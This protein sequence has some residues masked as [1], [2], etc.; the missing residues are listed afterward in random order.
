VK[1]TMA[2]QL[3]EMAAAEPAE[4]GWT[5]YMLCYAAPLGDTSRPRMWARHYVGSY[6][7]PARIEHHRNGTCGAAMCMAFHA[8]GIPFL[9]VRTARG[10]KQLERRIK[11]NGH[12]S[13]YC[14]VCTPRPRN[15]FWAELEGK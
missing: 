7:N 8:A 3:A 10:G 5:V 2:P 1:D 4:S 15:G 14:P 13:Q 9:V 6:K 11:N 12:H